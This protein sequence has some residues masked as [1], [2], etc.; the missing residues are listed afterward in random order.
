MKTSKEQ[1]WLI[2]KK[3]YS[4]PSRGLS[5]C[6]E[7]LAFLRPDKIQMGLL[8]EGNMDLEQDLAITLMAV[9][10]REIPVEDLQRNLASKVRIDQLLIT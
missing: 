3:N 6:R 2:Y 10:A 9:Q 7:E 5:S 1:E 8:Q 4:R